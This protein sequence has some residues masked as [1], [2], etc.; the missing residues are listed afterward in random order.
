VNEIVMVGPFSE[1]VLYA[2]QMAITPAM[3]GMSHT[4]ENPPGFLTSA[5]GT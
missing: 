1:I 3:M 5:S 2:S 4:I